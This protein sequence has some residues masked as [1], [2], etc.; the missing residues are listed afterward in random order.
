MLSV[1][2]ELTEKCRCI[3]YVFVTVA[4]CIMLSCLDKK[5]EGENP[6]DRGDFFN[7]MA[8][9]EEFLN[10]K[11]RKWKNF[12]SKICYHRSNNQIQLPRILK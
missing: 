8:Q 7:I 4:I 1:S 2:F 3:F 12:L 6:R 11:E 9:T 10:T 5:G